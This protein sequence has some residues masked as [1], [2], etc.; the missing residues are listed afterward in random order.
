VITEPELTTLL[1]RHWNLGGVRVAVHNGGMGSATWFVSRGG[2]RWV[3]KLVAPHA[4]RQFRGGLAIAQDLEESGVP[5]GAPVRCADG[6]LAVD[7]GSGWLALLTWVTGQ[8]LTGE[9]A[10]QRER[11]GTTLARVHLSLHGR[12]VVG[13]ERFHWV[14]PT[15]GYLSLRP[16]LRPAI[17]A[18][19]GELEAS[20]PDRMTWGL[21][22][23]DPAPEAFRFDPATGRCGIIDWSCFLHGPLLYDLASAVM[24]VGGPEPADDLIEAYLRHGPLSRAETSHGLAAM[25]RFRW[26]VQANYFAWRISENDL[27][28]ISGPQETRKAWKTHDARLL[29]GLTGPPHRVRRCR[30]RR[31]GRRRRAGRGSG[32]RDRSGGWCGGRRARR[33]PGRPRAGRRPPGRR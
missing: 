22:H 28:G 1:E 32:G 19:L 10:A 8:P 27:T 23:A 25:L 12:S 4:G 21:L 29:A 13:A 31:P 16:W 3:A 15:A 33:R 6:Q 9:S 5:A 14:D 17:T 20:G 24:Y 2:E 18:A 30:A 11:I 26:A 7:V